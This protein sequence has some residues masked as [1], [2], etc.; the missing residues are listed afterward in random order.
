MAGYGSE[1]YLKVDTIQYPQVLDPELDAPQDL[2]VTVSCEGGLIRMKGWGQLG[3]IG[4][5]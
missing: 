4:N 1:R 3:I 2:R 5:G